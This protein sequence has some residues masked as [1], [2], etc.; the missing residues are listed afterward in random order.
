ML[1]SMQRKALLSMPEKERCETIVF[2]NE[3]RH[4]QQEIQK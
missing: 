1:K 3:R 4:E 2:E